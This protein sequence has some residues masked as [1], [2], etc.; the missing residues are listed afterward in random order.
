MKCYRIQILIKKVDC[1]GNQVQQFT[2]DDQLTLRTGLQRQTDK[3]QIKIDKVKSKIDN[4]IKSFPDLQKS[5]SKVTK[6][7]RN[8]P[9]IMKLSMAKEHWDTYSK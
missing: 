3:L 6:D 1:K 5:P 7:K 8:A 9:D 2:D 4:G